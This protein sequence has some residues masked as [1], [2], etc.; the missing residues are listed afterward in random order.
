MAAAPAQVVFCVSASLEPFQAAA[1]QLANAGP[2]DASERFRRCLLDTLLDH[3][4]AETM[5]DLDGHTVHFELCFAELSA[6]TGASKE[7]AVDTVT[8]C[9][10]LAVARRWLEQRIDQREWSWSL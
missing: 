5:A 4:T 10:G 9:L 8:G 2:A 3:A 7:V 1:R 6:G